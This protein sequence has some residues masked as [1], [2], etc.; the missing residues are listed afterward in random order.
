MLVP[1]F[2]LVALMTPDPIV[3]IHMQMFA[4]AMQ[5]KSGEVDEA[6]LNAMNM[7]V[8]TELEDDAELSRAARRFSEAYPM[9]RRD[10]RALQILGD[11]LLTI[12]QRHSRRDPPDIHRKDIYG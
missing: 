3:A 8:A 4:V 9:A 6:D 12:V 1:I 2:L 7:K 10:P 5:A 11:D